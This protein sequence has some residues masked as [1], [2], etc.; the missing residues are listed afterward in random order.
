MLSARHL[1]LLTA[2]LSTH[3]LSCSGTVNPKPKTLDLCPPGM[4]IPSNF[5]ILGSWFLYKK[6]SVDDCD[7]NTVYTAEYTRE[8]TPRSV[9][10]SADHVSWIE[11]H[12]FDPETMF[13][14]KNV[15]LFTPPE[16][17]IRTCSGWMCF[18]Y[19]GD[20][21]RGKDDFVIINVRGDGSTKEFFKRY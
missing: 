12:A 14:K 17:Y 13:S 9:S 11:H 8:T 7:N 16:L 6:E 15:Y 4:H 18:R 20:L 19:R 5:E 2:L 3:A 21:Y 10:I 1:I